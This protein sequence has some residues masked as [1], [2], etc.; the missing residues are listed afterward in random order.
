[1]TWLNYQT[2]IPTESAL[3]QAVARNPPLPGGSPRP[4]GTVVPPPGRSEPTPCVPPEAAANSRCANRGL[5]LE[6]D[7]LCGRTFGSAGCSSGTTP[8]R[9][10]ALPPPQS[11]AAAQASDSI[12]PP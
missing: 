9:P 6:E 1:M 11:P 8:P 4:P 3:N 2:R 5:I 12:P 7:W 10:S